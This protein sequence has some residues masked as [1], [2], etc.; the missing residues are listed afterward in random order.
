MT[1]DPE[2]GD[3]DSASP[4]LTAPEEL[5]AL[6]PDEPSYRIDQLR[7]WL[8]RHPVLSSDEMTNLPRKVREKIGDPLWPF[9][10]EREN[11]GDGGRTIKWLFRCPDGAA[12]EA[13]LMGYPRRTTLCISSQAGC[14]MA[15]TFCATGQ[16]GF[17]RHLTAGEIYAQVAYANAHLKSRPLPR[18]PDRV[19]NVVFM[20]MGEPLANYAHVRESIRRMIEVGGMSGRSITVST[21][22]VVPG[23]LRLIEEPWPVT[24]AVSLHAADDHLREQLVPLNRRYP[25]ADL[26]DAARRYRE[27]KGRRVSLEWTLMDGVNDSAHQARA[28]AAIAKDLD[29]HVNIIPMNPT[30]LAPQRRPPDH[31]IKAFVE[32]IAR[33]GAT[34][35]LRDTRGVEIDAACGQLRVR[36][37]TERTPQ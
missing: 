28:L 21:V 19:T 11:S 6:L 26:I 13:V 23:I 34:V 14:A 15:C 9:E 8:Y 31:R 1:V 30:P 18:S 22:G 5:G 37:E 32:E 10:V 20:G 29:A 12:I 2:P 16:F 36:A 33:H 4:Y 7:E 3:A 17:E 35:T 25:I 24:L 27:K